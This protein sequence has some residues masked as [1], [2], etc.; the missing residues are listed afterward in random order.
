MLLVK[1]PH[2]GCVQE[3]DPSVEAEV[4]QKCGKA[5]IVAKA[6]RVADYKTNEPQSS[7]NIISPFAAQLDRAFVLIDSEKWEKA[8]VMLE[9]VLDSFPGKE[10]AYKAYLGKL[11]VSLRAH[12]YEELKEYPYDFSKNR[13][14]KYCLERSDEETRKELQE[15][16]NNCIDRAE[17]AEKEELY[18]NAMTLF[19]N[20]Q[21]ETDYQNVINSLN[22]I[23]DYG[24]SSDVINRCH[25]KIELLQEEALQ[26]V[27]EVA[28]ENT[29]PEEQ[30]EELA[31]EQ[32]EYIYCPYCGNRELSN[33]KF[34]SNCGSLLE[35]EDSIDETETIMEEN[36][37][38][39][40]EEPIEEIV[41][42]IADEEVPLEEEV[43]PVVSEE[44]VT[45]E[46]S[47]QPVS[48]EEPQEAVEEE[49]NEVSSYV[50][51]QI[52]EETEE[53]QPIPEPTDSN[54]TTDTV[55]ES[56]QVTE[57]VPVKT[58]EPIE[59]AAV[60]PV[61]EIIPEVIAPT[62]PETVPET[63]E[64]K[65]DEQPVETVKSFISEK[66]ADKEPEE[67]VHSKS[68]KARKAQKKQK[69]AKKRGKGLLIF[70]I[71]LLLLGGGAYAGHYFG[72]YDLE[73]V[74][75]D[76]R[77][78]ALYYIGN[79]VLKEDNYEYRI[80]VLRPLAR[81]NYKDSSILYSDAWDNYVNYAIENKECLSFLTEI[82]EDDVLYKKVKDFYVRKI[83][84]SDE[85]IDELMIIYYEDIN[86]GRLSEITGLLI[87]ANSKKA[88]ECLKTLQNSTGYRDNLKKGDYYVFGEDTIAETPI[89][90][91]VAEK[92]DNAMTLI[93]VNPLTTSYVNANTTWKNTDAY[94]S[95]KNELYNDSFTEEEKSQIID[96]KIGVISLNELTEHYDVLNIQGGFV[97]LVDDMDGIS[98]ALTRS[99][100]KRQ[101]YFDTKTYNTKVFGKIKINI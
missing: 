92:D 46:S 83:K 88:F 25:E 21:T 53:S 70:L 47:E 38:V 15:I 19:R 39:S 84:E 86:A 59:V 94:K 40:E 79:N 30:H 95:L 100:V 12:N 6:E 42:P 45:E 55:E 23:I 87:E 56:L 99:T 48:E 52:K 1:C 17:N 36:I 51:D 80:K 78:E 58:E 74:Y 50:N 76:V 22:Q 73:E 93:S 3:I 97:L 98:V 8:D 24:N 5:F 44:T 60:E 68:K 72:L 63:E 49:H 33:S 82:K 96:K 32:F 91:I 7:D 62:T 43:N 34:C 64:S 67:E 31:E 69:K 41:V 13:Y 18:Q 29:E 26:Q 11:L 16:I 27:E 9:N 20:A 57:E 65:N 81:L 14:L 10:D 101:P 66:A 89:I 61:K 85:Y 37:P 90:W 71:F 28:E 35:E 75:T 54:E 2:C 77:N 4:C